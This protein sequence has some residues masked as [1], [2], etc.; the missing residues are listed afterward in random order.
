MDNPNILANF[1]LFVG[2]D[3]LGE[4]YQTYSHIWG[5]E[6]TLGKNIHYIFGIF[7]P[8]QINHVCDNFRPHGNS[9]DGIR[10]YSVSMLGGK[11]RPCF[12][13]QDNGQHEKVCGESHARVK[14]CGASLSRSRAHTKGLHSP[15]QRVFCHLR[16]FY[17]PF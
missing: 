11:P 2:Q 7:K 1:L 16:T 10:S 3:R 17:R 13:K 15:K 5:P 6:N 12:V 8:H 4:D 14:W 9:Y